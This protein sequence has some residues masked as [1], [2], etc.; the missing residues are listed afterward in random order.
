MTES[1]RAAGAVDRPADP[2]LP[3]TVRGRKA[4]L[5]ASWCIDCDLVTILRSY[6][7]A[8]CG[9]ELAPTTISG[10]GKLWSWTVVRIPV[11]DR[12]PPYTLG[13][14]DLKDG[15]RLLCHMVDGDG[16]GGEVRGLGI[17]DAATI[18]GVNDLGDPVATTA[19]Q[20]TGPV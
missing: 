14:V 18:V 15:P 4:V 8:R 20:G 5:D 2:R 16:R 9:G 7:C 11:V 13:Y 17:G 12:Q 10:E 6:R 3:I 1:N 19:S